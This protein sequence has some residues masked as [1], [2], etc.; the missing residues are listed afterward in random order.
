MSLYKLKPLQLQ[1]NPIPLQ[2]PN[3]QIRHPE[4]EQEPRRDVPPRR[5]ARHEPLDRIPDDLRQ[6]LGKK[7]GRLSVLPSVLEASWLAAAMQRI[8]SA[9]A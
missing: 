1:I 4:I 9:A 7:D 8:F 6:M 5:I 3:K 2:L